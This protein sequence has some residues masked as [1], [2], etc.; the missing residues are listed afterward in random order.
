MNIYGYSEAWLKSRKGYIRESTYQNYDYAIKRFQRYFDDVP[1]SELSPQDISG[2]FRTMA[3][4][5]SYNSIYNVRQ[6]MR[7]VFSSAHDEG[8]IDKN[9]FDK[10]RIPQTASL[11]IV[12]AYTLSE[13]KKIIKAAEDDELGDCYIF[14]ILTGLRLSEFVNLT[15]D[16][17]NP[18]KHTIT[19]RQSKTQSGIATIAISRK[20]ELII[21]RQVHRSH[22]YIFSNMH[23][24][25]IST[26]SM[27]KLLKR[28][29]E[30]TQISVTNHKCRHTFC[31]RLVEA[32]VDIKTVSTL[33]RHSSVAFTLQRYV[34]CDL[35]HQRIA[36][37]SLD[38]LVV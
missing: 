18:I 25:P 26:S 10:I 28:I 9:P 34:S 8:L 20:A 21:L 23:G 11:K 6:I 22:N 5:C 37:D 36:L 17:Y 24:K 33:A 12:E 4:S 15:W 31:T 1:L 30:Q 19:I 38:N 32:G 27:K 14:L 3:Y 7:A 29:K 16:D 2:T 13:Q 35:H